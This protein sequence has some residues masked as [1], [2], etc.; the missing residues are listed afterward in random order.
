VEIASTM[1]IWYP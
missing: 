1:K